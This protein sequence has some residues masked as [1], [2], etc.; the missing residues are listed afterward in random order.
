MPTARAERKS[1]TLLAMAF[2]MGA[3]LVTTL[4]LVVLF[5]LTIKMT[6]MSD[7]VI[8]SI[9]QVIKVLSIMIGTFVM[10]R[11]GVRG[12]VAGLVCGG[13]YMLV[14]IVAYCLLEGKL[15]PALV[16]MGDLGLGLVTGGLSG[17]LAA[18]LYR[19]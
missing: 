6:D 13:L 11:A 2:G 10:T 1:G 17:L 4:V 15:L 12:Y 9:N 5:A 3:A 18:S 14:G 16:M 19:R 8:T 7:S